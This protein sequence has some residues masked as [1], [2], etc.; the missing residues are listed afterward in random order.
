MD[1]RTLTTR[2]REILD[3]IVQ[4]RSNKEI[5]RTL[6]ISPFTVK[7]H[8]RGVFRKLGVKCR[9]AAAVTGTWSGVSTFQTVPLRLNYGYDVR[10]G[11]QP[12]SIGDG[13]PASQLRVAA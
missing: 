9:A 13:T 2:Q 11:F 7:E 4:G 8:V 10:V 6:G 12:R 1:R 5:A 3:L